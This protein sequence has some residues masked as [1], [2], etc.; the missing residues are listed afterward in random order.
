[1]AN[2]LTINPD[3]GFKEKT[4]HKTLISNFENGAEQRRSK[5]SIA[6]KEYYLPYE[7]ISQAD[8]DII[9]A[10]FASKKGQTSSLTWT[11]PISGETLTVRFRDEEL[12]PQYITFG[13][14]NL[15]L[16]LRSIS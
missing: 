5:T 11:H 10:L 13:L 15:E 7:N 2:D 3:Y 6:I 9:L 4:I 12:E 8:L 1:M 16:Y 14:W